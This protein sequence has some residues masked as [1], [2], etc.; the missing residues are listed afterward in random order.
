M[1]PPRGPLAPFGNR[2]FRDIWLANLFSSI[3]SV[4]QAVAAAW[5]MTGLTSQHVLVALVQASSTIPILLLG[6]VAGAIADAHDRRL[7]MLWAQTFMLV[8]SAVLSVMGYWHAITPW[9]LLLLTLLVGLGT[10]LNGPAW[11]ASVRVQVDRADLPQAISLN[12]IAFN[13]AR[14]LGPALGGLVISLWSVN[15]AFALNAVSYLAMIV[16]LARWHPVVT[17]RSREPIGTAIMTGV[18]FCARSRPIARVL[19]RGALF[20]FGAV[21][22]QALLPVVVRLQL[23]GDQIGYGLVVGAFGLGSV[24]AALFVSRVRRRFG[25][26]TVVGAGTAVCLTGQIVLSTAHA[27]APAMAAALIGGAGWVAVLTSLNVAI[28]LRS[29]EDILARCLSIYQAVAFGG[30]ALGAWVWG[31]LADRVGL[32]AALRLAALWLT[33]TLIMRL[34]APMPQR[35][36]GRIDPVE[37]AHAPA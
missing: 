12:A 6:V 10:A 29:P 26:E 23:H 14:S 35:D 13:L 20:G 1:R 36:E 24:A 21:A 9:S 18:L 37:T 8:V 31:T 30:M 2:V 33:C 3:G 7:V 34:I 4:M 16:V 28:Q 17:P 15:A 11:Q 25:S 32:G 22:F 19:A 27:L 5:M